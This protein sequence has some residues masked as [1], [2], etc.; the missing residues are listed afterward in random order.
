MH[1][2]TVS[3][4]DT[5][6]DKSKGECTPEISHPRASSQWRG[7]CQACAGCSAYAFSFILPYCEL[8]MIIPLLDEEN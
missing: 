3:W 6:E 1:N 2:F 8:E 7:A 4:R 5:N